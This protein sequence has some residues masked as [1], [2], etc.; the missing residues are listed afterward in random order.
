MLVMS[1]KLLKFIN[2]LILFYFLIKHFKR[3]LYSISL[4]QL[5]AK[6]IDHAIF[7]SDEGE[8]WDKC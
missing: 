3:A 5:L 4:L 7:M 1:L 6:D 8:F 2:L